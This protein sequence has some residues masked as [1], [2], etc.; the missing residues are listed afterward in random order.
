VHLAPAPG[1]RPGDVVE[2]VATTA[3]PHYLVADGGLRSA[4]R[5]RA[6]D[7]WEAGRTP[8]TPGVSLGMPSFGAP[9]P[10]PEAPACRWSPDRVVRRRSPPGMQR[11]DDRSRSVRRCRRDRVR[12]RAGRAAR[13][14]CPRVRPARRPEERP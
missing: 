12:S 3:G 1:V 13:R 5:T 9:A 11:A 4:R 8:S 10:L 2:T 6:G 7:A 14:R